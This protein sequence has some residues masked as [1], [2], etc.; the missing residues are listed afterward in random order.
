[1]KQNLKRIRLVVALMTVAILGVQASSHREAPGITKTPKVDGTDLYMFRSFEAGRSGFVTLLANYIPFQDPSDLPN[2]FQLDSDALYE[3]HIDND[4]DAR[5]DL[6]FRF[7]F[8]NTPKNL[9][10]NVGGERIAIPL[11]NAGRIGP[12]ASDT[13]ALNVIESYTVELI[14]G[15]RNSSGQRITNAATGATRFLKPVDR[16]GDKSIRDDTNALASLPPNDV[17]NTYADN[18]IYDIN[19]PG[20]RTD[21]RMFVGQRREG[22]VVNVHEVLDLIN[23]N[24]IGP[25]NAE[26][27]DLA[28]KNVTTL[29]L[30]LP[31]ACVTL[32]NQPI[33]GAW[34]TASL[35][36]NARN[37]KDGDSDDAKQHDTFVQASRL[38]SPLVNEVVIGYKDKDRFNASDPKDDGRFLKYVTHPSLPAIIE[39]LFGFA[40]VTAP[41]VP[42]QDLVQAFLTGIPGL[43]QPPHIVPSEMLR[44]NTSIAPKPATAQ[45]SL[46]VLAGDTA[47]FPNGRRPGDDVV[48]IELRVIMGV[49][50]PPSQAPSGQLPYT[51]GT[52]IEATIAYK[53]NG[54]ITGDQSL[55]LFRDSFPYLQVPLSA[56]PKPIHMLTTP[57]P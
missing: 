4:G 57:N 5:E 16:I 1:M 2:L 44:L 35:P 48:D 28:G 10:V 40:G 47:G 34:T 36:K 11:I 54:T 46:G 31:I 26:T 13:A 21:G 15:D 22:F 24:P 17:Y 49:L 20:C 55:R 19:I 6:T 50:L 56:S 25:R 32:H 42:R 45:N 7:R 8:R 43:N 27:N 33:I 41:S 30:E 39:S 37:A 38:G 12:G 53:P 3:I 29:S 18:H 52:L 9:T 51:D 14:R 23:T